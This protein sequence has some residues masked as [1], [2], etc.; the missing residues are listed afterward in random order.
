MR[1][2]AFCK[3]NRMGN[4]TTCVEE[5]VGNNCKSGLGVTYGRYLFRFISIAD[6]IGDSKLR[7]NRLVRSD[8]YLE[9]LN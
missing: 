4:G 1:N 6:E 8:E 3:D 5:H 2:G 7:L 9:D